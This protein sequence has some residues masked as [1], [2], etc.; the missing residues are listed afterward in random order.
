MTQSVHDHELD[1][2][3]IKSILGKTDKTQVVSEGT[4]I[5]MSHS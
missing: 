4:V 2:F 3:T 5:V 1:P